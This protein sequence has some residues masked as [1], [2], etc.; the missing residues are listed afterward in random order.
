L[1]RNHGF[2]NRGFYSQNYIIILTI[3]NKNILTLAVVLS[4]LSSA[5]VT[6]GGAGDAKMAG[7]VCGRV[8][9]DEN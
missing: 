3:P 4:D 6:L 7:G 2:G 8:F 1:N 9:F 5:F